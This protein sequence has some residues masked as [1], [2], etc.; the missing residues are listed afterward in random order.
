M[1]NVTLC[2]KTCQHVIAHFT[3][4]NFCARNSRGGS[5]TLDSTPRIAVAHPGY[6]HHYAASA[7]I[8]VKALAA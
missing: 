7:F 2:V 6:S 3:E 1:P 8:S 4:C 5:A